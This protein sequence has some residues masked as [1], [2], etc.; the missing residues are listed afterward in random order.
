M[1]QSL[2]NNDYDVLIVGCGISG[3]IIAKEL[4]AKKKKSIDAQSWNR[5]W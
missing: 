1:Y 4:T 2:E 5:Q 3:S